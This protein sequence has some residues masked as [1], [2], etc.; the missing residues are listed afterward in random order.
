MG[1]SER[2]KKSLELAIK[3]R[4][5]CRGYDEDLILDTC[6]S[7][8]FSAFAEIHGNQPD[9]KDEYNEHMIMEWVKSKMD[10]YKTAMKLVRSGGVEEYM[11]RFGGE[12]G[13]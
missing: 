9:H 13:K 5:V 7:L 1:L 8:V 10:S 6:L 2:G 11:K 4:D 12:Y 3:I